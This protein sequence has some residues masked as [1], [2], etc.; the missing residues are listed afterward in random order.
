MWHAVGQVVSLTEKPWEIDGRSGISRRLM[1]AVEGFGLSTVTLS[2]DALEGL[3]SD[4]AELKFGQW[5]RIIAQ[6]TARQGDSARPLRASVVELLDA[7][8]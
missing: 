8:V 1:F 6:E 4:Y 5:V 3:G 7:P 2:D